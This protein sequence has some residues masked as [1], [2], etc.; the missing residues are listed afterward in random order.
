RSGHHH[1]ALATSERTM[2]P[3]T[4]STQPDEAAND[5]DCQAR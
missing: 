3:A 2:T 4:T 5:V 1:E